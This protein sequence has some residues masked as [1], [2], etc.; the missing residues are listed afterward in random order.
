[1]T[2]INQEALEERAND[3]D[4]KGLN[5]FS[6]VLV[7][8]YPATSP[9]E[10]RLEVH[11]HNNNSI[12]EILNAYNSAPADQKEA[13]AKGIFPVSGGHRVIGGP[14]SDQVRA[15][16]IAGNPGDTFLTLTLAPIGDYSTYSL[17]INFQAMDPVFG[18]MDFK[19]R[20]GCFNLCAPDWK[21]SPE[22]KKEPVIDYLAKDYDSF[23]HALISAMMERVP[24]WKPASEADFDQ[25][26]IDL[27]S[28]AADELSDYQ[29][30]VMNEAY[31][32]TARKR[33]SLA[34][35][36]RLMD[37]HI[38]Q[39]NQAGTWLALEVKSAHGIN[40]DLVVWAGSKFMDSSSVVFKSR[41]R[42]KNDPHEIEPLP[43]HP[44]C[45][46]IGLYTWQDAV[47]ALAAGSRSA[48]L[49]LLV[50]L[51]DGE[52]KAV[53]D[54]AS[55]VAVQDLIRQGRIRYLV[56]RERLNPLTGKKPGRNPAKRQL[57]RLVSGEESAR[58]DYDPL[59]AATPGDPLTADWFVRVQWEE[60]DKLRK[61]YCFTVDCADGKVEEVSLFHGNLV[62]VFHGRGFKAVF[63][64]PGT[65]QAGKNEGYY[66]RSGR[67]GA[68][69]RLPEPFLAYKAT[70]AGGGKPPVSTLEV[71]VETPGGGGDPWK[72]VIS[73]IHSDEK[74][75]HFMV[76][77][78]EM[79]E[80][81]IRFGNGINGRE[82]PE[83]AVVRCE[84]QAGPGGD[85]NIGADTLTSFDA[86]SF[87]EIKACRNPF[88]VTNG[89][90]PEPVK[91]ILRRVPE[92]Y[93]SRQFRAVTLRDYEKRAE[94]LAGVSRAAARYAWTG[95]WRTVEIAVDPVGTTRLTRN[96]RKKIARHLDAVRLIGE[97]LEIRPPRFVP[98]ALCVSLCIHL[99]YWPEDIRYL[100]EQEFSEGF[101]Q[102][103]RMGFFHPDRWTF[104]RELRASQIIGRVQ[105]VKGVGHVQ[106]VSMKRWNEATLG[107]YQPTDEGYHCLA[108]SKPGMNDVIQVK[109][110]EIIQARNDP[111][112]MEKGFILFDVRGGRQ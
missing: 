38:H 73:L 16:S 111:D 65:T 87:P 80:S 62:E 75:D 54:K 4:D 99:D 8:L 13:T 1:M 112:H 68:V 42:K 109:A 26:L 60:K 59:T 15:I 84:F 72:E 14:G 66:E 67:W 43:L 110:N 11:F 39:G 3:L 51:P 48:D 12:P 36:A 20:P 76:E 24:N 7:T 93:G 25:V 2:I 107:D 35:H 77:T 83:G 63:K 100:L 71:E 53:T 9:T 33:V 31:L 47:P 98:L 104:G 30:R 102:D 79:G 69:C 18:E 81:L 21:A 50:R 91:E 37:Y 61:N 94:E 34:R 96:L 19:F 29:D 52:F 46:G 97:D 90:T 27:F 106:G 28:G 108:F 49:K 41:R 89:R 5:G 40:N 82:L 64:E 86:A 32:G 105:S 74:N 101:T 22:P 44:L 103:G 6:R 70:P 57:L 45:N 92:A 23:R 55:A 95:S 56:I 88:D 85:G 78:D 17:G 10:A 58:A